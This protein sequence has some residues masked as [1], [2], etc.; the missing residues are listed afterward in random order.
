MFIADF[1]MLLFGRKRCSECGKYKKSRELVFVCN[2]CFEKA[3]FKDVVH[4]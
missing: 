4:N 2:S 1:I 3:K